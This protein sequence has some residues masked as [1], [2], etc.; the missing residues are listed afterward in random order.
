ML[1]L[2][3]PRTF[4]VRLSLGLLIYTIAFTGDAVAQ[5]IRL[6]IVAANLTSGNAQ[7]YDEGHGTRILQGIKPDIA[8]VQEFRYGG[9]SQTDAKAREWVNLAFGPEYS[10]YRESSAS[11]AGDIP[12]GIVSR[13][14]ILEAGEWQDTAVSNRDFAWARID[15]PGDID[16]WAVSVHFLTT[17]SAR[18][19]E[20]TALR[21][22]ITGKVPPS[23]YLVIGGDFNS[24]SRTE[25]ALNTLS[26]IV[27]TSGPHPV[28]QNGKEGTNAS[29][30]KPYDGVYADFDLARLQTSVVI[31]GSSFANGLV[32]DT[33]VYTPLSEISPALF[34]DSGATNMQHMAVV[35]DFLIPIPEPGTFGLAA[36]GVLLLL[37][38]R[39]RN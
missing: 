28:D 15:I 37:A 31:G 27:K 38:R 36:N 35:K 24:D 11:P 34:G 12:N 6:R 5:A 32:V 20:A 8:L 39:R 1:P 7:A 30:E 26:T 10:Y 33:R 29:R 4:L 3:L 17:D 25:A 23:D 14:P 22:Y 19:G 13:Y 21:N 16:L 2:L 9:G 18:N